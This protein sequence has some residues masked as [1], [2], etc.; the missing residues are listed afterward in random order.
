MSKALL[1]K[2]SLALLAPVLLC[3]SCDRRDPESRT[4]YTVALV[5]LDGQ[6]RILGYLPRSVFA[7]RVSPDGKQL[8]FDLADVNPVTG[9]AQGT[10]P[11]RVWVAPIESLKKRRVLPQIGTGRN[12]APT[13]TRDGQRL[14][15][16]ASDNGTDVLYWELADGGG[17]V[18]R[19]VEGLSA[20]D[21]TPDGQQL[22]FITL[23]F[24]RDYDI[25]LLDLATKTVTVL[26][27]R[28]GSEQHSSNISPGGRWIAYASNETGRHEIWVEPLPPTGKRYRVTQGGGSHPIWSPDGNS[29]Y[30][31]YAEQIFR[32]SFDLAKDGPNM[33]EP[34]VGEPEGLPITGFQQGTRRRQFDLMPDGK[35]FLLLYPPG[36]LRK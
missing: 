4:G 34:V 13:W 26:V 36:V 15:L 23:P 18:E 21:T 28:R 16:L 19:L 20:E 5:G 1:L 14:A 22:S 25:S 35:H 7:P 8:A 12:W 2:V 11:E 33:G 17:E 3:T 6:S 29:I 9:T 31:D 27:D 30:Y 32:I 10:A 24:D